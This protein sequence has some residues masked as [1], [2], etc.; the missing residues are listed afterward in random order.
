[1][2]YIAVVL[3]LFLAGCLPQETPERTAKRKA[4]NENSH[5]SN[6]ECIDGVEY[7]VTPYSN[8]SM[9]AH[10]DPETLK[11]KRC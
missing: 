6:I 4:A 11:P 2:K 8:R 1:M 10:I 3:S 5:M 9:A 7:F